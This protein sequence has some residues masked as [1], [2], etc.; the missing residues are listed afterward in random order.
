MAKKKTISV[1]A[2]AIFGP[3]SGHVQ[4]RYGT[5]KN[6]ELQYPAALLPPKGHFWFSKKFYVGGD[7]T[8]LR[9]V[10]SGVQYEIFESHIK[11][12]WDTDGHITQDFTSGV[13]VSRPKR[14]PKAIQ[15]T[16]EGTLNTNGIEEEEFGS[17]DS[18]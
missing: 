14:A 11:T 17:H 1:C 6:I 8:R 18:P 9:F 4:Y 3:D 10:N 7:E 16:T 13:F 15:C 5:Q 2:S 12:G